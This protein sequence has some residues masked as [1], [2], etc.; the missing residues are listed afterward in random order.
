MDNIQTLLC[1]LRED[2][3]CP[4][5]SDT[6]TDPKQ[7]T[8]LHSF[9]LQCLKR[10]HQTSQTT[11][12]RQDSVICP[13]CR[14]LSTVPAN[15]DLKDL[16]TSFYL[17]GLIDV[18]AIKDCNNTQVT[19][20]NCDRKS[21]EASYCFQCC[22][23]YCVECITAHNKIR[24]SKDHRALALKDF[25]DKDF[26][27][28]LKRPAFC[29]KQQHQNEEL[30]YF[31]K[32]C[33]TAVCQTCSFLEHSGHAL[34]EHIE[35]EAKR[36]KN[37][38]K[39]LI[40]TQRK[41]LQ[42][43]KEI[44]SQLNE[45]FANMIQQGIDLKANVQMFAEKL[46]GVIE[47]KKQNVLA[48]VENQTE[49]SLESLA[50]QKR[51][52]EDEIRM[53]ESSLEKADKLLTQGANAEIIQLKKSLVAV[54]KEVVQTVPISC[55]PEGLLAVV[56]MENQKLSDTVQSEE[57]GSLEI[58][59]QTKTSQSIAEGKGLNE[60][61]AVISRN[62]SSQG[63]SSRGHSPSPSGCRY[64]LLE[65]GSSLQSMLLVK[66][67]QIKAVSLFGKQGS[68]VGMFDI[69]WGVAVSDSDEIAVT[70]R[71]NHRVQLFDSSGK[72]L[73]SFGR[74]GNKQGEFIHPTGICFDNNRNI[75][76]ADSGNNRIQIF[77]GEGR[78]MGMFTGMFTR[79]AKPCGLS[80]DSNANV[81]VADS[82]N[83]VITIFSTDGELHNEDRL[84]GFV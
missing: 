66:P 40:K 31:C 30:K 69:P 34:V 21:S 79:L 68:S 80:L 20:G 56:F 55:D 44:V 10:W 82:D 75:L 45:D 36:Q 78:Y 62:L 76:V 47:A 33:E 49:K 58:L 60:A 39:T 3:C 77:S 9:C 26:E 63:T 54:F 27:D 32:T 48:A 42:A 7:L 73:R 51:K 41:N 83:K 71:W 38:I 84:A 25:Q 17:N 28:L 13:T 46:I 6:F 29:S 57:I 65:Q 1:N 24:N 50:T 14:G 35:D 59:Q 12:G 67:F 53:V 22:I 72:Y 52:I 74:Q 18:L 11:V 37:E 61:F 43:K 2:V 16:P 8:C 4:I 64:V 19:C 70:D 81:I 5:C 23:F 15:G